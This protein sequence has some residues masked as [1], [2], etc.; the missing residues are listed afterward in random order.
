ME[1][2]S[3]EL[4]SALC[5]AVGPENVS[6]ERCDLVCYAKDFSIALP[7]SQTHPAFVVQPETTQQVS[8][9]VALANT[10]GMPLVPRGGGTGMWGG[11]VPM[12]GSAVL[13]MRRMD[14]ILQIDEEKR[15]VT[16]QAG[17]LMRR[18][19]TYLERRGFFVADQ[20][21]SWFAAT[22]GARTQANGIGYLY[23]SRYGHS[24]SQVLCL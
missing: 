3:D 21:E 15:T 7:P 4:F 20:P 18:L 8:D 22:V 19:V 10:H 16:V 14:R 9:V 12:N 17:V 11:A 6:R 13:D 24:V 2:P 1:I 5:Q 23:N